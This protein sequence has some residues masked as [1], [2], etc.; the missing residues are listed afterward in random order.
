MK[1][2]PSGR[3][4]LAENL[5]AEVLHQIEGLGLIVLTASQYMQINRQLALHE[6]YLDIIQSLQDGRDA[7][8]KCDQEYLLT[9]SQRPIPSRR[10]HVSTGDQPP[11][12]S[13]V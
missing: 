4:V 7:I 8:A 10:S 2:T 12:R 13:Q 11:S 5:G 3:N 1:T 9:Y 6:R